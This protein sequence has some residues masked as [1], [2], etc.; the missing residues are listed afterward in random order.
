[1]IWKF[2]PCHPAQDHGGKIWYAS[3]QRNFKSY[4]NWTLGQQWSS[5]YS[6]F[7]WFF[8]CNK[9]HF[10]QI[11]LS[12]LTSLRDRCWKPEVISSG[13][14][15]TTPLASLSPRGYSDGAE[16]ENQYRDVDEWAWMDPW[17]EL[18]SHQQVGTRT[19]RR[20][21]S[22]APEYIQNDTLLIWN[23]TCFLYFS[24]TSEW[25]FKT[26]LIAAVIDWIRI[27]PHWWLREQFSCNSRRDTSSLRA[28]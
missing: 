24:N 9:I 6:R 23:T 13:H 21:L 25:I 12:P 8:W 20:H 11:L 2:C 4:P 18:L 28:D 1:M 19:P 26:E 10:G 27:R 17:Q 16:W 5:V 7:V 22:A 14:A 3:K 15:D